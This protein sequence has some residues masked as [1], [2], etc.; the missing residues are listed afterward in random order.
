MFAPRHFLRLF[1]MLVL[2]SPLLA[3]CQA[4]SGVVLA[5]AGLDGVSLLA[6]GKTSNGH[7]LSAIAGE[8]CEPARLI[9][10]EPICRPENYPDSDATFG[11]ATSEPH[12]SSFGGV[13]A[14]AARQEFLVTPVMLP[15]FTEVEEPEPYVVIA[16]F[17]DEIDARAVAWNLAELPATTSATTVNGVRYYRMVVGPLDPSLELVLA[18]RLAN[19]GVMSFY[20]VELCPLDQSEPPCISKPRYRPVIDPAKV[21]AVEPR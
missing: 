3:G 21:A 2:L 15:E 17:Q 13:F 4:V 16:S 20:P 10:D 9:H 18:D 12:H 1:A 7:S 19:A 5:R 8:D 14:E 6:T 11:H